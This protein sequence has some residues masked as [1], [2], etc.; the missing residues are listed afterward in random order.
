LTTCKNGAVD[1]TKKCER[2]VCQ[3]WKNWGKSTLCTSDKQRCAG[4][5]APILLSFEV[6]RAVLLK[7]PVFWDMTSCGWVSVS[8][9][10][11]TK[12]AWHWRWRHQSPSKRLYPHTSMYHVIQED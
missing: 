5:W 8:I 6:L 12:K 1:D 2:V 9:L 7:I 3:Q 11:K 10:R 4:I